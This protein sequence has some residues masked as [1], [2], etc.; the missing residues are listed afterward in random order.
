VHQA[1]SRTIVTAGFTGCGLALFT[2]SLLIELTLRA[3]GDFL[4]ASG[5]AAML[6]VHVRGWQRLAD[7][8]VA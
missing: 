7:A 8:A 6:V 3:A 2:G 1:A 4:F 5:W